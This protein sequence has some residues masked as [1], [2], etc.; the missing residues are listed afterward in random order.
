VRSNGS[1]GGRSLFG[2][3][4]VLSDAA[5]GGQP[6]SSGVETTGLS[7]SGRVAADWHALDGSRW[8]TLLGAAGPSR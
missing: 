3:G 1:T 2:H 7:V 6:D 4:P 8:D 5:S